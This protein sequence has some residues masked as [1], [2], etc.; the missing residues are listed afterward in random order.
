NC[1]NNE[2]PVLMGGIVNIPRVT[3]KE[4]KIAYNYLRRFYKYGEQSDFLRRT[5][6]KIGYSLYKV[7]KKTK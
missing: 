1:I 7:R 4:S 2:Y 6:S 5:R 3:I